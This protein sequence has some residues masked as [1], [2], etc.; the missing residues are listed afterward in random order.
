MSEPLIIETSVGPCRLKRSNRKTLAISVLPDGSVELVAPQ[1]SSENDVAQKVKRKARWIGRQRR[2][3]AEMNSSR[4]P[5]KYLSG[6]T[7]RYLGKQYRLKVT[8]GQKSEVKLRGAFFQITTSDPSEDQVK[9]LLSKWMRDRA[10]EQFGR[11]LE[12]WKDWCIN[13][14]LPQP[15]LS[16]RSMLKRWGS[17]HPD[18]RIFLNPE[19]VRAPSR[20]ID[21]VIAHEICHLKH[22][23]HDQAFYRLLSEQF[24]DWQTV[25]LKLEQIET[26]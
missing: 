12:K 14:K 24:P 5:L 13:R 16:L 9:E 15:T 7:H 22:P 23:N 26:S 10:L 19:L 8:S 18:G 20:C 3:F 21:Y 25:K 11:R 17:A 4:P 2:Q 1:D 6:A